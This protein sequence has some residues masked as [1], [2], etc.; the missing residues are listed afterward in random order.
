MRPTERLPHN[1]RIF[2][3]SLPLANESHNDCAPPSPV[4]YYWPWPWRGREP[5]TL[6]PAWLNGRVPVLEQVIAPPVFGRSWTEPPTGARALYLKERT[7]GERPKCS[8]SVLTLTRGS[9]GLRASL[10]SRHVPQGHRS[11]NP[12]VTRSVR[13]QDGRRP[14]GVRARVEAEVGRNRKSELTRGGGARGGRSLAYF[15]TGETLGSFRC[16]L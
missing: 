8:N 4:L 2:W 7:A 3:L 15:H 10:D 13:Q 6:G 5:L 16:L 9:S 12:S 11:G 14:L 1:E